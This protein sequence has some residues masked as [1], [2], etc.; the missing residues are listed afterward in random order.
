[1]AEITLPMSTIITFPQTDAQ[2]KVSADHDP[3]SSAIPV[4]GNHVKAFPTS[5]PGPRRKRKYFTS[6]DEFQKTFGPQTW[7][8]FFDII[9]ETLDDISLFKTIHNKIGDAEI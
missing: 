5:D 9:P 7:A 4:N 8:K 1:M 2:K 3:S 6:L